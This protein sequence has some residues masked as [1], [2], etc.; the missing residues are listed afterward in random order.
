MNYRSDIDG[1]RTIA[2]FLVIINHAGFAFLPGGFIGVDVFFVISGFLITSIIYQRYHTG[3]FSFSWFFSR[4]IKRLMPVLLFVILITSIVFSAVMLPYD[5]VQYYKSVIWVVLY[6]ANIFLWLE[7]GGYFDGGSLEVPLL[8]TWSLAVEEQYYFIWPIMLVLALKFLGAKRT[9]YFSIFLCIVATVFSQ[10]GTEVTI[11]AAYYLLPTRFF[12]LLVGSCLA[13]TWKQLPKLGKTPINILSLIGLF[14]ILASAVLITEHHPF[15]GYN[16][17]YS[18]IGTALL[19]YTSGGYIN[20][21]LSTKPMVFTG[22]ISYSLYL[23]HWPVFV[24]ARYTAVELTLSVQIV[25]IFITY[26]LSILSWKYIEQPFR[27][28]PITAFK[29]I[30]LKYYTIPGALLILISITGIYYDGYKQRFSPTIVNMEKAL[31]TYSSE[32]RKMCHASYRRSEELPIN[33]CVFGESPNENVDLFVFGDSHANHLIPMFESLAKDAG[34]KGQDYTLDRCLPIFNLNWGSNH[35]KAELCRKRNDTA[36]KHIQNNNFNYVA[37]A[38]SW[39]DIETRRIFTNER[40]ENNTEKERLITQKLTNTLQLIIDSGARP[41][42]IEDTPTLGGK[43]PKCPIK[44][45]IFNENLNCD[46]KLQPNK[47]FGTLISEMKEKFPQLIV[48]QPS[49]LFCND[50]QCKMMIG[51]TPLYRD[52]DHLNE[53]G[54]SLIGKIYLKNNGNPFASQRTDNAN[55]TVKLNNS[56]GE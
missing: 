23:W 19:I 6:G 37:L 55:S 53:V 9:V 34:I 21:V 26:I 54:A 20:K 50:L 56:V 7:H 28:A 15:P 29:P 45:S 16:A 49:Q 12:E 30:A 40:V 14:L 10:W 18:V 42:L 36:A 44:K 17:L 24:F 13:L 47:L 3:N 2:V 51:D 41:I 48:I 4:R 52:D 5:L 8:H 43:S 31:K 38:A 22:N 32:S 33:E 46:I 27:Q 1:L 39:P 25:C 11:G 35:H